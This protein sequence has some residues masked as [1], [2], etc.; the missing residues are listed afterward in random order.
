MGVINETRDVLMKIVQATLTEDNCMIHV[1]NPQIQSAEALAVPGGSTR[2][3]WKSLKN[4]LIFIFRGPFPVAY[5]T[6]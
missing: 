1:Q 2:T 5:S 3:Q 6:R 4:A